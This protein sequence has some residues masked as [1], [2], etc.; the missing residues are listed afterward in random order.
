MFHNKSLVR[1]VGCRKHA[2]AAAP[3]DYDVLLTHPVDVGRRSM[4]AATGRIHIVGP[5]W[6][7]TL[8][9]HL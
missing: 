5:V 8:I 9:D 1:T 6:V 2:V 4:R 3:H 7:K